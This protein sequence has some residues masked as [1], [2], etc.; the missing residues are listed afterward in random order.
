VKSIDGYGRNGDAGAF[1]PLS[2]IWPVA[3]LQFVVF[4]SEMVGH[5]FGVRNAVCRG[6]SS[7]GAF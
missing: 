3:Q 4:G 1:Y 6:V 2:I 7:S 5:A